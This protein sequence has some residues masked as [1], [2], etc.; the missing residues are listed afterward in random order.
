M[1][2]LIGFALAPTPTLATLGVTAYVIGSALGSVLMAAAK[3]KFC[4]A[5]V[6]AMR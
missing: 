5:S 6:K 4:P 3:P 2:G 1:N